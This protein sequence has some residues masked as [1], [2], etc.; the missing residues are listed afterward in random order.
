LAL[1]ALSFFFAFLLVL[2]LY[3]VVTVVVYIVVSGVVFLVLY[4]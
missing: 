2:C 3:I 1:K 4:C